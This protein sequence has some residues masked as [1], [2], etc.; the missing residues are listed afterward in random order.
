MHTQPVE[1][2]P[3]SLQQFS[4]SVPSL[5]GQPGQNDT[6]LKS[7]YEEFESERL[8]KLQAARREREKIIADLESGPQLAKS[9]RSGHIQINKPQNASRKSSNR[10]TN[11]WREGEN[12]TSS[13]RTSVSC[14]AVK[15]KVHYN[16]GDPPGE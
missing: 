1:L 11:V 15:E 7:V 14:A 10:E 4:Q 2:L 12:A 5:C 6:V 3:K 8:S 16:Q 9:F 13:K